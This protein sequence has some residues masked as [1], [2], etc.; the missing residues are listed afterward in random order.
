[1]SPFKAL[2]GYQPT[3]LPMVQLLDVVMDRV[4][5]FQQAKQHMSLLIRDNMLQAQNRM[6][7]Y[8]DKKKKV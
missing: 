5:E 1:M 7:Q 3:S 4:A 8:A 6:R 2:Y